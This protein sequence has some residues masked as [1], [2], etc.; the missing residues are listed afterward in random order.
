MAS[1]RFPTGGRL[2]VI[3][4]RGVPS[5]APENSLAGFRLA[6]ALHREG[7][8]DGVELDVHT[9]ADGQFVVHHDPVLRSGEM[10]SNIPLSTVRASRLDDGSGIPTLAEALEVL[11][12][13]DVFVEVKRL[14]R[15]A[16]SAFVEQ[17][18]SC[19]GTACHVHAFDH[20]VIAR[21]RHRDANMP[22]G[23]LSRSYPIDPVAQV[24]DAG[25]TTLWQESYLIDDAL[26]VTCR[27]DGV[28]LVAWPVNDAAEAARLRKAGV[29]GMCGDFPERLKG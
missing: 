11:A 1:P 2:F 26:V 12:G 14:P 9:T 28:A 17:L 7:V 16:G 19:A 29:D 18:R 25:A 3:G 6:A 4:H 15:G 8:C 27:R 23:V 5:R 13:L 24:H 20:R 10:I 21:L 22:L